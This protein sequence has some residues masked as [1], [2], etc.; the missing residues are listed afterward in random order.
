MVLDV[1]TLPS[2]LIVSQVT[3]SLVKSSWGQIQLQRGTARKS[4]TKKILMTTVAVPGNDGSVRIP[5]KFQIPTRLVSPSFQSQNLRVY[6]EIIFSI[7]FQSLGLLKSSQYVDFTVPIGITNLPYNHL[8]HIPHLTSVQSYHHS[9]EPPIF[10][11]PFLDE[12][13][14]QT[15][16]PSELWGPLTAALTTPPT[17]SPPNYFSLP[18]LPSQF[19]QKDREQKTTFTSRLIKPGMAQEFGDPITI[20]SEY[21]DY[22]W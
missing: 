17:T 15:G 9:K 21:K 22:S 3:F 11:D 20:V 5:V 14:S 7:Q 16:I 10:F 12:P 1:E 4:K 19:I 6:Y 2:D 8:L 13:P 18:H